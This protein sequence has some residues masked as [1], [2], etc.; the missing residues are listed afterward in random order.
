MLSNDTKHSYKF[1][2]K[3]S[4]H[5]QFKL[6]LNKTTSGLETPEVYPIES[7]Q[8]EEMASSS[9]RKPEES[10]DNH[11]YFAEARSTPIIYSTSSSHSSS[12]S[13]EEETKKNSSKKRTDSLCSARSFS[14]AQQSTHSSTQ[15]QT[16]Y[17]GTPLS[18]QKH[19][20]YQYHDSNSH[21]FYGEESNT[22]PQQHLPTTPATTAS[23]SF[24]KRKKDMFLQ[25]NRRLSVSGASIKSAFSTSRQTIRSWRKKRIHLMMKQQ[26][27]PEFETNAFCED[28]E[29]YIQTRI[30]YKNGSMVW[31]VSF[32][33]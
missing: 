19:Q 14:V 16:F 9:K 33:L 30:R 1:V 21:Y 15:N 32:T 12:S 28:C 6:P 7:H 31:L 8:Q 11:T 25:S 23:S 5:K 2:A 22:P 27:L 4:K 18:P 13:I 17:F 20:P 3:L 10:A 29:K 24:I 26:H